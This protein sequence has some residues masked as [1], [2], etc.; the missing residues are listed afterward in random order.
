MAREKGGNSAEIKIRESQI[1]EIDEKV[2]IVEGKLENVKHEIE[3]I[4]ERATNIK[5]QTVKIEIPNNHAYECETK[6]NQIKL[7][8]KPLKY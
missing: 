2:N 8:Q 6:E 5:T 4:H 7:I 3:N 1:S